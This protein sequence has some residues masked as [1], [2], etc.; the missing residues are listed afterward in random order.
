MLITMKQLDHYWYYY[1]W[2]VIA[3]L[4]VIIALVYTLYSCATQ[5]HP[6]LVVTYVGTMPLQEE[7]M[8]KFEQE[9]TAYIDDVN[10]DNKKIIALQKI[11]FAPKTEG[12]ITDTQAEYA[13][14]SRLTAEL[15]AGKT[16]LYLI[17]NDML[18]FFEGQEALQPLKVIGVDGDYVSLSGKP[19]LKTLKLLGDNYVA[20]IRVEPANQKEDEKKQ[21]ENAYKLL[22]AIK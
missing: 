19:V 9:Y 7:D 17:S 4:F 16:T 22:N 6:D 11:D 14:G 10:G 21:Y 3:I 1:K 15:M 5:E 13:S 2:H 8:K 20:A 18:D 12:Q